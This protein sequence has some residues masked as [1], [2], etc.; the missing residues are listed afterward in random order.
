MAKEGSAV[1]E[2]RSTISVDR[3]GGTNAFNPELMER[4]LELLH[5]GKPGSGSFDRELKNLEQQY[6]EAVYAELLYLLSHLRFEPAE[7]R[8]HWDRIL[9][10]HEEMQR[11][12]GSPVDLRVAL[13][14]YFVEVD[15]RLENPKIIELRVFEQTQASVYR[16]ELTGLCNYRLLREHL[17]LE[18]HQARRH[19]RPLSLVMIDIDDFKTY[20]DHNGHEAGNVVLAKMAQLIA[21]S[22]R[23]CDIPARYGGEE[24]VLVLP[25]TPKL[26]A[27]QVAERVRAKIE[28]HPFPNRESQPDGKLTIS[29]GVATY[30]A[31]CDDADSLVRRADRAMYVAK[32]KGKNNVYLYG[33]NTRSFRRIPA[34]LGGKFCVLGADFHPLS[35]VNISEGG[36]L[37]MVDHKLRLGSLIDV[38]LMLPGVSREIATSGRVMRVEQTEEGTFRAAVRITEIGTRDQTLLSKYIRETEPSPQ[39]DSPAYED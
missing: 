35:T 7:A 22:L 25:S 38:R 34:T 17:S 20:N 15:R 1:A 2:P 24:F 14:S 18:F 4:L 30:P 19:S 32:S 11:R 6:H 37:L 31:D 12:L 3:S 10:H 39:T 21:E 13:V 27:G 36:L 23:R 26:E 9:Q 5:R 29:M 28:S 16:D 8:R 33:K